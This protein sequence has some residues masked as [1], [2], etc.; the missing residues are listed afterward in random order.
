ML[1][2]Q[3]T[4]DKQLDEEKVLY[5][6]DNSRANI[7]SVFLFMPVFIEALDGRQVKS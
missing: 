1:Q 7:D 5:F 2:F 4:G 3:C 6:E